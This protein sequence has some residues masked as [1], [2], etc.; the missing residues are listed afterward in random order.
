MFGGLVAKSHPA[1]VTPGTVACQAPLSVGFPRQEYRNGLPFP[2]PG[3]LPP[4]HPRTEPRSPELQTVS[5]VQSPELQQ[6]LYNWAIRE[7]SLV[8]AVYLL[9]HAWLFCNPMNCSLLGSSIH[10][11]SWARIL[12]WVAI[13]FSRGSSQ[14]RDRTCVSCITGR[15]F[16]TESITFCCMSLFA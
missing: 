10:G 9:S 11:V 1:L 5:C 8:V 14:P 7:T 16:T 6:I 4:P 13:Y 15:L 12:E 2:S 3:G